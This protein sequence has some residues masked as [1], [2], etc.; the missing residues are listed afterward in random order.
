MAISGIGLGWGIGVN[1]KLSF[2]SDSCSC[3]F[4]AC[5]RLRSSA[6]SE[7]VCPAVTLSPGFTLRS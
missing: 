7:R 2:S 5:R 1:G 3:F 6:R 4:F